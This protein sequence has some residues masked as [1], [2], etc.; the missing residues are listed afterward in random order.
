MRRSHIER[1]LRAQLTKPQRQNL[2]EPSSPLEEDDCLEA[3]RELPHHHRHLKRGYGHRD[4]LSLRLYQHPRHACALS[5]HVMLWE[6]QT[7][8]P[9]EPRQTHAQDIHLLRVEA[10]SSEQCHEP[11]QKASY[12]NSQ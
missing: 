10:D 6:Q 8:I 7:L 4:H 12:Y 11:K 1:Y 3:W 5:K 2:E 9:P